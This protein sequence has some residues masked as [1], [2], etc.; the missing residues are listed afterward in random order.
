MERGYLQIYTGDGK[1]KTTAATGLALR[2]AG[3]G[4]RVFIGQ[5]IKSRPSAE[6]KILIRAS[7][8]ITIEQFGTGGFITGT[9]S[10]GEIAAAKQGILRLNQAL[11]DDFDVVI[12]DEILGALHAGV[13]TLPQIMEL[14]EKRPA[15]TE[16]VL[17]GRDAPAVLLA[18]ADLATE[19]R[20]LKH[21]Y[22]NGVP[23]RPGIEY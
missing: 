9:P 14:T 21:Y 22:N 19:M 12:A 11:N 4:L 18:K 8:A 17:T 10:N 13:L 6:M 3:A 1:G 2:A 7:Q 23:A 16:L 20:C 15:T 5:F